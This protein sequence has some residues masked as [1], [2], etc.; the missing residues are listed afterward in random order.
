METKPLTPLQESVAR[1]GR[2]YFRAAPEVY[3]LLCSEIDTRRGFPAGVETEAKTL[4]SFPSAEDAPK[5]E[6]GDVLV[7]VETWRFENQKTRI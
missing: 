7:S 5:A 6:N 2:R 3:T 1:T 4:M